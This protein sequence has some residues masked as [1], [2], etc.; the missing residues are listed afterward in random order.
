MLHFTSRIVGKVN[1][2]AKKALGRKKWVGTIILLSNLL[3]KIQTIMITV[4]MSCRVPETLNEIE[5]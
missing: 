4:R 2:L 1:F 5:N 3:I